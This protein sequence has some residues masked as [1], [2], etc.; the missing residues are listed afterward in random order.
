MFPN[1]APDS[2]TP[3]HW[4]IPDAELL[5]G[6]V[7][8]GVAFGTENVLDGSSPMLLKSTNVDVLLLLRSLCDSHSQELR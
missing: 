5:V 2:L 3:N 7:A 8:V 4:K 1:S 6:K